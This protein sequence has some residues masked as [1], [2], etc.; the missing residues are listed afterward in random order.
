VYFIYF[1]SVVV[2]GYKKNNKKQT[3]AHA[4]LHV[5]AGTRR[6]AQTQEKSGTDNRQ[7]LRF[8]SVCF[9]ARLNRF[10]VR[11]V[12]TPV[13]SSPHWI[14]IWFKSDSSPESNLE[15]ELESESESPTLVSPVELDK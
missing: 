7:I 9:A 2:V 15:S 5:H 1:Y 14:G 11:T 12:R 4:H 8:S 6:K 13:R 3:Q 10:R